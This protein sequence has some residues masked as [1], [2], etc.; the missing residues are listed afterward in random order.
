M[1]PKTYIIS[2]QI[3]VEAEHEHEAKRCEYLLT[4]L[5]YDEDY[6]SA[7]GINPPVEGKISV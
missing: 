3:E 5:L 2:V 1:E 7:L 6:V 4:E